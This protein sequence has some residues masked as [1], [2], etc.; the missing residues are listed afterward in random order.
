MEF[1]SIKEAAKFAN[2]CEKTIRNWIKTKKVTAE[3]SVGLR[4][5]R[6]EKKSLM[7]F[8]SFGKV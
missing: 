2:V 5:W 7:G 6:V 4:R 8:I 1:L 3:Y